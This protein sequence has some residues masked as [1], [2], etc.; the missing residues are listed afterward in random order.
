MRKARRDVAFPC[1]PSPRYCTG[2]KIPHLDCEIGSA[3]LMY[4]MQDRHCRGTRLG[5][6]SAD[7]DVAAQCR[8]EPFTQQRNHPAKIMCTAQRGDVS[9]G[10]AKTTVTSPGN[11]IKPVDCKAQ[12]VGRARVVEG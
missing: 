12:C 4:E 10:A 7:L 9:R 2:R 8:R 3:A 11:G 1:F 5:K 6:A